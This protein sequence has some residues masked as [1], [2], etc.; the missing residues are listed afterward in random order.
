MDEAGDPQ[1]S[2]QVLIDLKV[3]SPSTEVNGDLFFAKIPAVT[4]VGELK[5]KIRDE[6][7]TRPAVERMRLIYRGRVMAKDTDSMFDVFGRD[8]VYLSRTSYIIYANH[9]SRSSGLPSKACISCFV[10]S[11]TQPTPTPAPRQRLHLGTQ[12]LL[13]LG[14]QLHLQIHS[15]PAL[16]RRQQERQYRRK[17][18]LS[19][20]HHRHGQTQHPIS[21][22]YIKIP[23][24][25]PRN[26][27]HKDF[28]LR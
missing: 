16:L 1:P 15:E 11:G 22:T 9:P 17:Q 7:A 23:S 20:L 3:L 27:R 6:L 18:T 28:H 21:R 13:R 10:N 5:I 2:E 26:S 24:H 12:Q 8:N 25:M 14:H 19:E 4:T